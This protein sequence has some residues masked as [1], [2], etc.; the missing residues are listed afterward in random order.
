MADKK[1]SELVS[2]TGANTAADDYFVVVDTSGAVTYK[3]SREELNN[4]IEQDVLSS[5]EITDITNDVNVQGTVTADELYIQST[6]NDSTV[7]TIQLAPSTT[8][9]VQGGLGVKSGGIIDVNGVNSVGLQVGGTRFVNV[10]S[11][12]DISFYDSTGVTQGF[13]WDASTQR[14]GLGT[15]SPNKI[16]HLETSG[17]TV[18]RMIGGT[19]NLVGFYL[20]DADNGS[21]GQITYDNNVNVMR[22]HT[23]GSERVKIDS[24]GNL[25]VGTSSA[26][27]SANVKQVLAKTGDCYLQIASGTTGGGLLGQN[28]ANM[29]FYT[30][31]GAVGSEAYAEAM[32]ISGGNLLVGTTDTTPW[33]NSAN[34]TADNGFVV[35][36]NGTTGIARYQAE[37]LNLNRTGNDGSI[38]DFQRSG[39]TVGSIGTDGALNIGSTNTGIKFGTSAVWA[40]TGGSTNSNGAKDLGASTVR[41]KDLYL[42][43]GI[44]FDSRSNKLNDYEEGTWTPN[45]VSTGATFST[46]V[47]GKYTKVGNLVFITMYLD[48]SSAPTGTLTNTMNIYG[49]PFANNSGGYGCILTVGYVIGVDVPS[50]KYQIAARIANG[51]SYITPEWYQDDST[52]TNMVAQDFDYNDARLV[53]TGHY[54]TDS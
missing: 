32:R 52:V 24:S 2:I 8:T 47:G 1:I 34:S 48:N 5:I 7:N 53:I 31:T 6:S 19:T 42:S 20:G 9:N 44:Q 28:G 29:L 35:S 13:F 22:F 14:L 30:Y 38:L 37:A 45:P 10:V 4:A 46:S 3:I 21:I 33:N 23:N 18:Q 17:E 49:L 27:S 51:N 12:G 39:T 41:W 26:P 36:S 15:T 54:Y 50:S 40:T 25:L 43:G 16:L 11:G